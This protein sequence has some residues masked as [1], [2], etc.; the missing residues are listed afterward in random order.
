MAIPQKQMS[1]KTRQ[2][3]KVSANPSDPITTG[4]LASVEGQENM[5]LIERLLWV[6]SNVSGQ[7]AKMTNNLQNVLTK[8]EALPK[9]TRY[10]VYKNVDVKK[11]MRLGYPAKKGSMVEWEYAERYG[12]I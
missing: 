2:Y 9:E 5:P 10:I 7:K 6:S 4:G 12:L 8:L 11:W 1:L 3:N